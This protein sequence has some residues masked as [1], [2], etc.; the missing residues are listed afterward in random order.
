M[1]THGPPASVANE[2]RRQ[3]INAILAG[4]VGVVDLTDSGLGDLAPKRQEAGDSPAMA[5]GKHGYVVMV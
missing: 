3:N 5:Y 2:R 4:S 1:A